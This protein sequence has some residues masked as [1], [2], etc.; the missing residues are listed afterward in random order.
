MKKELPSGLDS[1]QVLSTDLLDLM[2]LCMILR[3]SNARIGRAIFTTLRL[4]FR[5]RGPV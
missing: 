4:A 3:N 2:V 1:T 5:E